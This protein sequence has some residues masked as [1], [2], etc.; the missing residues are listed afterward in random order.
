[1]VPTRRLVLAPTLLASVH[2]QV[3]AYELGYD[4]HDRDLYI[5]PHNQILM[6]LGHHGPC[7]VLAQKHVVL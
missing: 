6:E 5:G 3:K 1:M 4:F 7:G 2:F